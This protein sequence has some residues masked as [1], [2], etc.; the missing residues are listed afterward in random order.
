MPTA[1]SAP[2]CQ[3]PPRPSRSSWAPSLPALTRSP[4]TYPALG[5]VSAQPPPPHTAQPPASHITY[6]VPSPAVTTENR[7]PGSSKQHEFTTSP[8]LDGTGV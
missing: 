5:Q 6:Q 4:Q 2:T 7:K 1:P 3:A 8:P